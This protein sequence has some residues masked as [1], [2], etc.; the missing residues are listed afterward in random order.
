MLE[1]CLIAAAAAGVS[2]DAGRWAVSRPNHTLGYLRPARLHTMKLSLNNAR[3]W[4]GNGRTKKNRGESF[5]RAMSSWSGL[6]GL[7]AELLVLN[8]PG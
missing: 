6:P 1:A 3:E 8:I 7:S 2:H 5:A 4:K